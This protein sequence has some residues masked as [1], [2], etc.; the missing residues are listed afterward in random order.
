MDQ[1]NDSARVEPRVPARQHGVAQRV[2][3]ELLRVQQQRAEQYA[4]QARVR[5]AEAAELEAAARKAAAEAAEA[6]ALARAAL[7]EAMAC[8]LSTAAEAQASS[9]MKPCAHRA[10][11]A[12]PPRGAAAAMQPSHHRAPPQPPPPG[13]R[14][15]AAATRSAADDERLK[16]LLL[17][18]ELPAFASGP[19]Q[20]GHST[21]RQPATPSRAP[22]QPY[23]ELRDAFFFYDSSP[24]DSSLTSWR[25][26]DTTFFAPTHVSQPGAEFSRFLPTHRRP[27]TYRPAPT[28]RPPSARRRSP[29]RQRSPPHRQAPKRL[30]RPSK[31]PNRNVTLQRRRRPPVLEQPPALYP[32]GFETNLPMAALRAQFDAWMRDNVHAR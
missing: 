24:R 25:S 11:P 18:A 32:G 3:L 17:P 9:Q 5:A 20:G 13:P 2:E 22:P 21:A 8:Q 6:A 16:A 26:K 4:L 1:T 10:A 30:V 29:H 31:M 12:A 19:L 23:S 15:Q 28:H 27:P 7:S 14:Q